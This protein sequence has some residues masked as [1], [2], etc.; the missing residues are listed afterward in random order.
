MEIKN[1]LQSKKLSQQKGHN[2]DSEEMKTML[3]YKHQFVLRN[4]L[5]YKKIKFCSHYQPSLQF[6]LPQNYRQQATKTCHDDIG[7]LGLER[8]LYLLKDRF[9]WEGMNNDMENHIQ[10]CDR[11]FCFKR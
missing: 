11:C 4:G 1:L 10:T 7:Y 5:L 9:Y 3:R 2:T 8:S 6:I